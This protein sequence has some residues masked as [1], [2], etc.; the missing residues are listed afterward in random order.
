[1]IAKQYERAKQILKENA[2][3]HARLASLLVEREVIF[4]EDVER[5]FGKRPWTS[6]TD[7]IL[8]N[9]DE[10]SE[11]GE[12]KAPASEPVAGGDAPVAESGAAGEAQAKQSEAD[13]GDA[14]VLPP[15]FPPM[16]K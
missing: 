11:S 7:E 4:A 13:N 2:E 14:P 15:P 1:M 3:G 5:I 9:D 16:A 12:E 10:K 8:S 6:R